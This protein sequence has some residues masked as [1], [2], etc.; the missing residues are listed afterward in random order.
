MET[1]K[2]SNSHD[3][4]AMDLARIAYGNHDYSS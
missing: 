4:A 2:D 3:I 1:L